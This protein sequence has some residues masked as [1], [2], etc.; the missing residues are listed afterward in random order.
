VSVYIVCNTNLSEINAAKEESYK[1][2]KAGGVRIFTVMEKKG[3][4]FSNI[5]HCGDVC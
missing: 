3:Y 2:M 5:V 1:K 4:A